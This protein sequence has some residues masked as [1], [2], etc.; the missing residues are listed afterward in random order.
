M[1]NLSQGVYNNGLEK[2][3][4]QGLEQGINK[5]TRDVVFNMLSKHLE[6][7]LIVDVVKITMEQLENLK[8]EWKN[9]Q[10]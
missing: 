6:D 4:A 7:S 8:K 5:K 10:Q 1:C 3:L 2:G 9:L